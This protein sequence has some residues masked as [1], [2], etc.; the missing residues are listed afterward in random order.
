MP[1]SELATDTDVR[2]ESMVLATDGIT[3]PEC[4]A[5]PRAMNGTESEVHEPLWWT[6]HKAQQFVAYINDHSAEFRQRLHQA[7]EY[8]RTA[9]DADIEDMLS[10]S[11]E[12]RR[13]HLL[14]RW[15]RDKAAP[16]DLNPMKL[17]DP[18]E[19]KQGNLLQLFHPLLTDLALVGLLMLL[20]DL[21]YGYW[22]G[23]K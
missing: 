2:W 5:I 21:G 4:D 3:S 15:F 7:P 12:Y 1:S 17:V 19:P 8:V 11:Q 14:L 22:Y 16:A 20:I 18:S 10:Q 23:A 6:K 13:M 9:V